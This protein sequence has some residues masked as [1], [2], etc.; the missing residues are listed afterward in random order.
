MEL[1][2]DSSDAPQ[3]TFMQKVQ[4]KLAE[5]R[6][7]TFS[8]LFHI[9]LLA[10]ISKYV[11]EQIR[12]NP[13]DFAAEGGNGLV[14]EEVTAQPPAPDPEPQQQVFTQPTPQINTPTIDAITSTSTVATSFQ[15][16][17]SVPTLKAPAT[18]DMSAMNKMVQQAVGTG[19]RGLPGVMGGRA[20]GTARQALMTK[21]KMTDKAEKAVLAG[22]R[23]LK[24][25][26]SADG[27]WG[28]QH[29]PAMTGLAVLCFLGHGETPESAEFGPTVKKGVDWILNKGTETQGRLSMTNDFGANPAVYEHAIG[30][31]ALGEYYSM[32]H[33]DRVK[34]VLMQAVGHI[35]QGQAPDGGW[36]Y[37]YT[38][39][40]ESDTSVSG[41]Q[42]QALKAAHLTNLNISGVDE[43]L[44]KAMEDLKRV[45]GPNGGFGYRKAEDKYSLTG[46]GV[47]CTYFWKGDKDKL[48]REG[49]KFLI[50]KTEKDFP[51]QYKG[52]KA[53]LYA[54]YYHTQAC[55]MFG[56][57]AWSK[58]NHWFQDEIVNAQTPDGSWPPTGNPRPTGG[59]EA[60]KDGSGPYY[61][62][63]MCVLML[64]V[65]YRYMPTNR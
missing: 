44:D 3:L 24:T 61:R 49:I 37:N 31:Y 5:S 23:W 32:T 16:Q 41:W 46:V 52:E 12:D 1:P 43:A 13:V 28:D 30:A 64:E 34:D 20:G 27:S 45:Q 63:T 11:V 18:A 33:D 42:I 53:D 22:L 17:P 56:G 9:I 62:T 55:L 47:L 7:F 57:S 29:K 8:L 50:E 60:Q 58:W 48:V 2:Q 65:F 21:N 39:G 19:M 40:P 54:W 59:L 10:I 26:Q 15:M 14:N 6:F 36:Q 25:H 51:V 35:V 4:E 38:K